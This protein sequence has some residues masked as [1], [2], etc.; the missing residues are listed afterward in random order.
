ML[1]NMHIS[2]KSCKNFQ[3]ISLKFDMGCDFKT[4]VHR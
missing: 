2:I 4:T 3:K 1:Q